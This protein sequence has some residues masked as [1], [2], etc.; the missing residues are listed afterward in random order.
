MKLHAVAG[1]PPCF[2]LYSPRG[3]K[4]RE[5]QRSLKKQDPAPSSAIDSAI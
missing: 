1:T 5:Q 4:G 2:T 3:L